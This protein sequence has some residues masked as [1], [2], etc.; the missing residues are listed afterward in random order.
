M[1][2]FKISHACFSLHL[3]RFFNSNS[4]WG[5]AKVLLNR[6]LFWEFSLRSI[7]L[8]IMADTPPENTEA[9]QRRAVHKTRNGLFS[10]VLPFRMVSSFFLSF[11]FL[12]IDQLES[13]ADTDLLR[14]VSTKNRRSWWP[15]I[16]R[17]STWLRRFFDRLTKSS[18]S[19]ERL[20]CCFRLVIHVLLFWFHF[21]L[22]LFSP[23]LVRFQRLSEGAFR[24]R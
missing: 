3:F 13:R 19:Q 20:F 21:L 18:R 7:S 24:L 9:A 15:N 22:N 10:L 17:Y 6:R 1:G 4:V 11:F 5:S 16:T 23:V 12:F 8:I 14:P 2:Y